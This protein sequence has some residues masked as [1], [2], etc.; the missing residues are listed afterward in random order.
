MRTKRFVPMR[1]GIYDNI[2]LD[3]C[4]GITNK[5]IVGTVEY[6]MALFFFKYNIWFSE[7][8]EIEVH[9]LL[10]LVAYVL[11]EMETVIYA[12]IWFHVLNWRCRGG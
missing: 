1:A 5:V 12:L 10:G 2:G 4:F 6:T 11:F 7:P 8:M 3:D 9:E